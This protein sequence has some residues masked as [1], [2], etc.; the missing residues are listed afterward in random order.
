MV[1]D[2][3]TDADGFHRLRRDGRELSFD[4]F[5]GGLGSDPLVRSALTDRLRAVPHLGFCWETAPITEA[6]GRAPFRCTFV[7]SPPLSRL[8]ADPVPFREHFG[9]SDVVAFSSLGGDARLVAPSPRLGVDA[10]VY[11]HLGVFVRG[12]P[13]AQV[14]ALWQRVAAEVAAVR[15]AGPRWLSTAGL[16]VSWLH[17]RLDTRPKYYRTDPFRRLA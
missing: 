12:A 14:D 1:I 6:S 8:T 5:L 9:G 13:E 17:V 15:P 7:E 3:V 2:W 10:A 16:G 11:A 4:G